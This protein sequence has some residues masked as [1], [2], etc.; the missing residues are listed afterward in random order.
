MSATLGDTSFFETALTELTGLQTAVVKSTDRPVP[1]HFDYSE[2]PL[3][4]KIADLI[5]AGRAPIYLVNFTQRDCAEEAQKLLSV[6]FCT[7][8]EKK[9]I[10]DALEGVDFRS[11]YGKEIQKLL[12]HGVGLHHAGL[13]PRYRVL[14]EKLAQKGLLKV[15]SGTDTLGV[16]VNVPIR[17]VLFTKLCKYDGEKTT[18]LACAIFSKSAGVPVAKALMTRVLS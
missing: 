8:E 5:A 15:I 14:V 4:F 10:A 9:K 2:R 11:P 18:H 16:G 6:D 17:T 1:L 3:H 12:K 7:K 13:L